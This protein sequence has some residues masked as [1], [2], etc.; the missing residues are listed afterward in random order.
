MNWF[1]ASLIAPFIWSLVNHVDKLILSRF[2]HGGGSG[3]LMIFV[4]VVAIPL[5]VIVALV[6]P[7]VFAVS[8]SIVVPLVLSGL[9]Y[10]VGIYFYLKALEKSEA[11]YVVPFWQLIPVFTYFFGIIFLAEHLSADRL[12]GGVIVIIGSI[13]LS[14][15][16]GK[17]ALQ[18]DAR[19][20]LTMVLSSS[21]MAL[22]YVLYKDGAEISFWASIFWNQIGMVIFAAIF[23]CVPLFWREFTGVIRLNSSGVLG[24]NLAEQVAEIVGVIASNFAILLAPAAVIILV[25]Y[26][27]QPLFVF[28]FGILF[29][30]FVPSLVQEDIS[31][32][33]LA[34]KLVAIIV[35]GVG[36]LF[37]VR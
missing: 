29:T 7:Q 26:T 11:S 27:A 17:K 12:L 9:L 30:L 18:F 24:L 25:E 20:M 28:A 5:A 34:R 2:F 32:R 22:G 13:I 35:M 15:H 21:T 4:G 3:G 23:A 1:L 19:T 33:A 10:N 14:T 36:L 31:R 8:A 16:I 37:V 6:E